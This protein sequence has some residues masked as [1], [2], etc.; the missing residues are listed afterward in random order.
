MVRVRSVL[1]SGSWS[2]SGSGSGVAAGGEDRASEF[3]PSTSEQISASDLSLVS[4][5]NCF[6]HMNHD[7]WPCCS[8]WGSTAHGHIYIFPELCT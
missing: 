5:I 7:R 6:L 1:G 4:C 2:G 8:A 3:M